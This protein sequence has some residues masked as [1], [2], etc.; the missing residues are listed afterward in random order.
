MNGQ[1]RRWFAVV[2]GAAGMLGLTGFVVSF[3]RVSVAAR[4]SFGAMAPAVPLGVDLAI[5]VFSAAGLLLA[6]L[7]M[8]ARW[9]RLVPAALTGVTI[10]LNV[11]GE[12]DLFG[13]T[14]HAA[15]PSLWVL[16]V[17]LAEHIVRHRLAIDTGTRMDTVRL[18]RWL[19]AP[20]AT[21]GL[22]RR[23]VLWEVRSYPEAL[24]WERHRLLAT[25]ALR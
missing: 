23:M 17:A 21:A 15:L 22:W 13:I 14:A 25:A 18:S 6:W 19:L 5:L 10:A 20:L 11:S 2:A 12:R 16:A 4:P 8:P 3:E 9:V 7:D 24:V 1:A